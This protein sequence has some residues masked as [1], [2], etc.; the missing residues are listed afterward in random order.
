MDLVGVASVL[1]ACAGFL[2]ND[3]GVTHLA[4][5]L[6]LASLRR[7]SPEFVRA[8]T[9]QPIGGVA[10]A[11]TSLGAGGGSIAWVDEAGAMKVTATTRA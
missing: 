10:P 11:I 3:S 7:A 6:G 5:A 2:G 9:G 1:S 4:A 8:H